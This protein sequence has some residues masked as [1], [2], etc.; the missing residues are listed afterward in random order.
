MWI[1]LAY[2]YIFNTEYIEIHESMKVLKYDN[3][4]FLWKK[5]FYIYLPLC[6]LKLFCLWIT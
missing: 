6:M 3:L 1:L 4:Y 2:T 5:I